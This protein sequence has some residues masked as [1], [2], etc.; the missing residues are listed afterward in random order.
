METVYTRLRNEFG[1]R[2][3]GVD[4]QNT[5]KEMQ[6]NMDALISLVKDAIAEQPA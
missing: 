2:R 3:T 6:A 4:L 1:H 5:R